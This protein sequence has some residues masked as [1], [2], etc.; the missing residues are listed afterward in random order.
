MCV[1]L[2][3]LVLLVLL[4]LVVVCEGG[5]GLNVPEYRVDDPIA[6]RTKFAYYGNGKLR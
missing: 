6:S 1:L 5:G 4:V 2:L 3:L